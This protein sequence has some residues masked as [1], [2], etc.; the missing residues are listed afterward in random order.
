MLRS[1]FQKPGA[2]VIYGA[3]AGSLED[4]GKWQYFKKQAQ[5]SCRIVS[6]SRITEK[7][8]TLEQ[9]LMQIRNHAAAVAQ[10]IPFGK[11]GFD[12]FKPP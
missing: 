8:S 6:G 9:Y 2:L 11:K 10:A 3:S 7:S 1:Q 12:Q 4:K 5:F